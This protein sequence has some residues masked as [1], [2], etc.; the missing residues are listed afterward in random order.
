MLLMEGRE[1][2]SLVQAIKRFTQVTLDAGEADLTRSWAWG[3]YDSEGVR[4]A[5]FR[6][7][8]ELR[9]L[10]YSITQERMATNR[11]PTLAQ[12]MLA[13]YHA[14]FYDM[15]AALMGLSHNDV[16]REPS[17]GEWSV[18]LIVAHITSADVGFYVAVRH[19]LDRWRAGDRTPAPV[20]AEVWE[21][22]IGLDEQSFANIIGGPWDDLRSYQQFFHQR[23]IDEFS[24]IT[25]GELDLLSQYWET[26]PMSLRFRLGRFDS[27]LRQHKVQIDKALTALNLAPGEARNLLRL[28]HVAL[29]DVEGA[30]FGAQEIEAKLAPEYAAA[31]ARRTDELAAILR[32]RRSSE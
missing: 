20:P 1:E 5:F 17:A 4:F 24:S 10:A 22:L 31:I 28:I 25:D 21:A 11:A 29:A 3:D 19:A 15:Q 12:R 23:V 30:G 18:H 13:T 16:E 8:E 14:A 9:E 26:T 32:N 2:L 6:T 27:H 7:Y